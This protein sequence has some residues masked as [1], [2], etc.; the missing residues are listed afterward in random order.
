[1]PLEPV[2]QTLN[3]GSEEILQNQDPNLTTPQTEGAQDGLPTPVEYSH[4]LL[5]GKTPSEIEALF[6]LQESTVRE[7]GT[8]LTD[9]QQSQRGRP[10]PTPAPTA[11]PDPR[12]FWD[13]PAETLRGMINEAVSPLREE[14]R[15][16][17]NEVRAP[18]VRDSLRNKYPDFAAL[19]PHVDAM[20]RKQGIRP[21]D[22]AESMLE[23]VYHATWSNAVHNGYKPTTRSSEPTH[24]PAGAPPVSIPQHRPSPAPTPKPAPAAAQTRELTESERRLAREYKMSDAD[25]LAWQQEDEENV[26]ISTIGKAQ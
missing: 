18:S 12:T 2:P 10:D 13:N 19:E 23:L 4:P 11:A 14:I 7:Q 6:R 21:E 24:T 22:A 16:A 17:R 5:K 26:T 15:S 25:Y 3:P 1:M 20:I 8:M 9:L